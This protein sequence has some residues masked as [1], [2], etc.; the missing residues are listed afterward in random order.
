MKIFD[1][2]LELRAIVSVLDGPESV[3]QGLVARLGPEHFSYAPCQEIWKS[4]GRIIDR[5][6]HV[7]FELPVPSSRSM[8]DAPGLSE[9]AK[10][11]LAKGRKPLQ[12]KQD[13]V[14]IYEAI[15]FYRKARTV[16]KACKEVVRTMSSTP[17]RISMDSVRELLGRA[18]DGLQ[19]YDTSRSIT[20]LIGTEGRRLAKS[21]LEDEPIVPTGFVGYDEKAG[22]MNWGDLVIAA[23]P[24]GG[25]KSTFLLTLAVQLYYQKH[26]VVVATFELSKRLYMKR[27]LC[28]LSGISFNKIRRNQITKEER[29]LIQQKF[30][31]FMKFGEDNNC[32]FDIMEPGPLSANELGMTVKPYGFNIVVAD[33][34]NHLRHT[35]GD[36]EANQLGYTARH[37]KN[38][39]EANHQIWITATQ[40]SDE[41][42]KIRYTNMLKE[43]ADTAWS[44]V[45][46]DNG[47]CE[48]SHIKHRHHEPF[49]WN[50]EAD[51]PRMIFRDSAGQPVMSVESDGELNRQMGGVSTVRAPNE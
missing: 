12:T 24:S 25:G 11:L 16:N 4:I 15:D 45:P 34:L 21:A 7:G 38:Q 2:D 8:R 19:N 36:K 40:L 5:R 22:G 43:E 27:L 47:F 51:F 48:V 32:H 35:E 20:K 9:E 14:E 44:W 39:A 49:K 31:E 6:K 37:M 13:V 50:L 23:A 46:D 18:A 17:D 26:S 1:V 10:V 33:H 30:D 29:K 41:T 28:H 42:Q 3:R